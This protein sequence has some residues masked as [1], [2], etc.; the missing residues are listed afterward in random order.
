[1]WRTEVIW[2]NARL[3]ETLGMDAQAILMDVLGL[4]RNSRR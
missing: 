1:M 3:Q 4:I 2:G